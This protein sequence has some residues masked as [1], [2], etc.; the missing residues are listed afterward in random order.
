M[1]EV[2]HTRTNNLIDQFETSEEAERII[3]NAVK[4]QGPSV[5]TA[6]YLSR[7]DEEGRSHFVAEG[8][9]MLVAFKRLAA[10]EREGASRMAD[11]GRLVG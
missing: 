9:A 6:T 8:E 11:H 5:L 1:F 4:E 10:A 3:V 7:V 2:I